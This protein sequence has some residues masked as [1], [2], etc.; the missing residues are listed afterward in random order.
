M[1]WQNL[2]WLRFEGDQF[3]EELQSAISGVFFVTDKEFNKNRAKRDAGISARPNEDNGM[4][5]DWSE[6]VHRNQKQLLTAML[7]TVTYRAIESLLDRL[8]GYFWGKVMPKPVIKRQSGWSALDV[9]A[10]LYTAVGVPLTD[11]EDFDIV[12]ELRHARNCCVHQ[13]NKPN[14]HYLA[15]YPKPRWTDDSGNI[16]ISEKEWVDLVEQLE[17]FAGQLIWRLEAAY[18]ALKKK[19]TQPPP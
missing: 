19:A 15:S 1:S 2:N 7:F 11:Q 3:V 18:D 17:E 4:L 12:A 6:D 16:A 5:L 14:K 8:L 9:Y 13:Q 10:A